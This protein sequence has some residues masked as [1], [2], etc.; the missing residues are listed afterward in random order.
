MNSVPLASA[1]AVV[2]IGVSGPLA[3]PSASS[4]VPAGRE[5]Y[6]G[7]VPAAGEACFRVVSKA[8]Q[9]PAVGHFRGVINGRPFDLDKHRGGRC[10]RFVRDGGVGEFRV[11]VMA[12]LG[13]DLIV[14]RT[15]KAPAEGASAP[16]GRSRDPL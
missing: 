3:E 4:E 13:E 11:Y 10:L 8:T 15:V 6:V 2:L 7:D 12:D 5:G 9:A 14:T 1:L 16:E